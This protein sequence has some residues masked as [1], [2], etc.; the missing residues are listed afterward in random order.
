MLLDLQDLGG[1]GVDQHLQQSPVRS[2][3]LEL[4]DP[5]HLCAT[6]PALELYL[7]DLTRHLGLDP[8]QDL[9]DRSDLSLLQ[10]VTGAIMVMASADVAVVSKAVRE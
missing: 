5:G 10:C 7:D 4:V 3:E 8:S 9:G 6:R 1:R 2:D